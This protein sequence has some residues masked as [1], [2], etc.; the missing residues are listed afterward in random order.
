LIGVRLPEEAWE[1]VEDDVE[2]DVEA[3]LEEWLVEE[4]ATVEAGQNV[5]NAIVL[6]TSFE[7]LA[8]VAGTVDSIVIASGETFGRETDLAWIEPAK[9]LPVAVSA[10]GEAGGAATERIPFTGIRGAVARNMAAAWQNPQVAA[11]A[12]VEMSACLALEEKLRARL[13][14]ELKL[15]TT[16]L[17]LRAVALTLAEHPRLNGVVGEDGAEIAPEIALGLA[18]NLTEGIVVPVI[19]D[20]A[21]RPLEEIVSESKRLA[22]AARAGELGSADLSGGTFTVSTLGATGIDW[23][24]PI[25]NSP[26]I[27]ILG[28]GAIAE[29]PVVSAGEVKAAPTMDLTLVYDHRAVDGH[30][31]SLM[32]AALRDRLQRA[33]LGLDG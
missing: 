32:L 17:L 20:V 28:V 12:R 26:Q 6:K 23:F 25:L 33:D 30:P 22:E 18:V 1:E 5:A 31:A 27:A 11:G 10:A 9:A 14:P 24:T 3:L 19:R 13:G 16:H 7:V 2:D 4:G 21:S 29:R 8:P 15:T